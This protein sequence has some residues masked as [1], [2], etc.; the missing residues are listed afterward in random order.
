MANVQLQ[1]IPQ[2]GE[3]ALADLL[4]GV[5]S[6][7]SGAY[8]FTALTIRDGLLTLPG[9]GYLWGRYS[10]GTG[11]AEPI[12]LSTDDFEFDGS[13]LKLVGGA[14]GTGAD[15]LGFRGGTGEPA[16]ELGATGDHY[17]DIATGAIYSKATGSW[18]DT[19]ESLIGP[20]GADGAD[21]ADGAAGLAWRGGSGAPSSGLGAN[22]DHYVDITTGAIYLKATGSWSDTGESLMGPAGA[23]GTGGA[24]LTGLVVAA[25]ALSDELSSTG[26]ADDVMRDTLT[27]ITS[28]TGMELFASEASS[29]G[30]VTVDMRVV[31]SGTTVRT[32]TL[33]LTVS[34]VVASLTFSSAFSVVS[35]DRV[36]FDVTAAGVGAVGLK[37]KLI[38]DLT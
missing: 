8:L 25:Y 10:S 27:G 23:D 18:E 14:G 22:G 3:L 34:T 9:T 36:A 20:T 26:V 2:H 32:E 5:R 21:G 37:V 15:G 24:T 16:S 29:S 13:T 19:G 30:S 33:S 31:R 17:V 1:D 12:Q 7:D 35:G 4:L 28:L 6:A 11:P 38:G